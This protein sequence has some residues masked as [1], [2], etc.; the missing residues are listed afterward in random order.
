MGRTVR[1]DN[2][3]CEYDVREQVANVSFKK[4]LVRQLKE[5]LSQ[6]FKDY[7]SF[8]NWLTIFQIRHVG[9]GN[10]TLNNR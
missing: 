8:P 10:V 1:R 2:C 9:F 7:F 5:R 3:H 6:G 4:I